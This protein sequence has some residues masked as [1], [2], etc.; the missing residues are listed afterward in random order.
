MAPPASVQSAGCSLRLVLLSE[1]FV[2]FVLPEKETIIELRADHFHESPFS[3]G[4]KSNF[5]T[6]GYLKIRF[7][8]FLQVYWELLQSTQN[9]GLTDQSYLLAGDRVKALDRAEKGGAIVTSTCVNL[10]TQGRHLSTF[11][12][13]LFHHVIEMS[14][15]QVCSALK[16]WEQFQPSI[17][18]VCRIPPHCRRWRVRCDLPRR[19]SFPT[20][21]PLLLPIGA[22]GRR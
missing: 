19:T 1:C 6:A 10:P 11:V 14:L 17:P 2:C 13:C 16:A 5:C 12:D 15:P 22:E 9:S 21:A 20:T 18:S 3:R 8:V 4:K 7:P